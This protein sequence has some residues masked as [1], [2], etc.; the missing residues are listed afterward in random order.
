ML[1]NMSDKGSVVPPA[2]WS[3][4]EWS[5]PR[6]SASSWKIADHRSFSFGE[7]NGHCT[8][9]PQ[10]NLLPSPGPSVAGPNGTQ[11]LSRWLGLTARKALPIPCWSSIRDQEQSGFVSV[12]DRFRIARFLRSHHSHSP[13]CS[14]RPP[15][16][17]RAKALSRRSAK[18][19]PLRRLGGALLALSPFAD[20]KLAIFL[21][22]DWRRV[23]TL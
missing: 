1:S 17:L 23:Q 10:L 20:G 16:L 8:L 6:A 19:C 9:V 15:F 22:A 13:R 2:D 5:M 14:I 3:L 21:G 12:A 4:S 11:P 18:L 7:P